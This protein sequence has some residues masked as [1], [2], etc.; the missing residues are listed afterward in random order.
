MLTICCRYSAPGEQVADYRYS[1][2]WGTYLASSSGSVYVTVDL[3]GSSGSGDRAKAPHIPSSWCTGSGGHRHAFKVGL[4]APNGRWN[5]VVA[6]SSLLQHPIPVILRHPRSTKPSSSNKVLTT[7]CRFLK[8]NL[9]YTNARKTAVWGQV[10]KESIQLNHQ[11][12]QILMLHITKP[13]FVSKSE[14]SFC[15]PF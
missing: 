11:E 8:E 10:L 9:I 3:H 7:F 6:K 12:K 1:N 4:R 2:H 5:M 15:S 13:I 14:R